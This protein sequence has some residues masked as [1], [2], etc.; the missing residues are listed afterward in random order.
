[1]KKRKTSTVIGILLL[2]LSAW[3]LA[4]SGKSVLRAEETVAPYDAPLAYVYND[5]KTPND[6]TDDYYAVT[7]VDISD[8]ENWKNNKNNLRVAVPAVYHGS[9]GILPVKEIASK[10]F[11]EA[12]STAQWTNPNADL[13]FVAVDF[14]QAVNLQTVNISAFD[15]SKIS[16]ELVLPPNIKT[17]EQSAFSTISVTSLAPLPASLETIS[18]RAFASCKIVMD[19]LVFPAGVKYLGTQLFT[20]SK[21]T[22]FVVTQG[23][24]TFKSEDGVV[25]SLNGTDLVLYPTAKADETFRIPT[26]V[27]TILGN[28]ISK[29]SY[30]KNLIL[31]ASLVDVKHLG[32]SVDSNGALERIVVDGNFNVEKFDTSVSLT[33]NKKIIFIL[34]SKA[35]MEAKKTLL[36]GQ[37]SYEKY[38]TLSYIGSIAASLPEEKFYAGTTLEEIKA[39]LTVT[40]TAEGDDMPLPLTAYELSGDVKVGTN[41]VYI[42]FGAAAVELTFEI[43]KNPVIRPAA[44]TTVFKYT[45]N[46]QTYTIIASDYYTVT[47]SEQ[48]KA[49]KHTVTV[50]LKDKDNY[51][52]DDGTTDDL[53]LEFVIEKAVNLLSNITVEDVVAGKTPVSPT[54]T[55]AF[56]TV[57][58]LYSTAAD[59]EYS[60]NV[61]VKPGTYWVKAVVAGTSNYEAAE[62]NPVSFVIAK[63]GLTSGAIAGI[64]IACIL[65][66]AILTLL[67]LFFFRKDK[68]LNFAAFYQGL[69]IK[70]AT[71]I[72]TIFKKKRKQNAGSH[73]DEN[74]KK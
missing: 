73:F 54:A 19:E 8:Y 49:G 31:P 66:A 62:S 3:C 55:A 42:N 52:W 12:T 1:M 14:S 11:S 22:S 26:G 10:A 60:S 30:M 61:P 23:N 4:F 64:A 34:N 57:T 38:I 32:I 15:S 13:D 28:A 43:F 51:E 6:K 36:E 18:Y 40:G 17:I 69:W 29:N 74:V 47:G 16:G 46:A 63:A 71:G 58:Y 45:G 2:A 9:E 33:I 53:S 65:A 24:K 20:N 50:A 48:T 35:A 44:D 27:T 59:G 25:Y 72:K 21:I 68:N 37:N 67:A 7:G 39:S 70:S 5:N 41:T 56:G